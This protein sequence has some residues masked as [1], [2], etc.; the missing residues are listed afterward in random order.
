MVD[1]DLL[2]S[3][4]P[5]MRAIRR[6]LHRFPETRFE[7][8]R[9]ASVVASHLREWGFE[10]TEG[11]GK[12]GV[13]GMLRGRYSGAGAIALRADMDALNILEANDFEHC[14]TCTG[15]MHACGHDGHTAMLLYA[16][17]YMAS[18]RDFG[19]T[20]HVIFQPAEEGGRGAR[21]MLDDGLFTRF[22]CD[23]VYGM[24]NKPGIPVGHFGISAGP[25][26]AACD[27]WT[28][29]FQGTGGH[30]GSAPHLAVD[31][32]MPAAHFLLGLQAIVGRNVPATETAVI[33]AG[34]LEG[35]SFASPN[36]MPVDVTV[37]G[38]ARWYRSTVGAT[39]KRRMR[40]LAEGLA[41][42]HGCRLKLE[43]EHQVTALVN[44]PAH[45][46]AA[47][48]AAVGIV[49][50]AQVNTQMKPVTGGEDFAYLLEQKP[51]ALIMI[52][53]GLNADGTFHNLHTPRYEFNDDILSLGARYWIEL[54]RQ[55]TINADSGI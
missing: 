12:T 27:Y 33:S 44:D 16:A 21:A 36:V 24:H 48:R 43:Y 8:V 13:V 41:Q 49:G 22:P 50:E 29:V 15:K 20:L 32:M 35:G 2:E 19:G 10:V 4:G 18:T 40:E 28:A 14:S 54:V 53:N 38:T 1:V 55:Q 39:V 51:G 9:T 23:A 3:Y 37:R 45:A 34:Y 42:A 6:D 7:E 25:M 17:R 30:G 26:M 46:A 52:G 47:A 11:V 31:A 5:Q